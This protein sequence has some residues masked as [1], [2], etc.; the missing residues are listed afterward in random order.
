MHC[1]FCGK[2]LAE[3][4]VLSELTGEIPVYLLDDMLSELDRRH[5][6]YILSEIK[7]RQVII[8][9]CEQIIPTEGFKDLKMI[10]ADGGKFS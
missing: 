5:R 9:S 3:G 7:D 2:E 4:E 10:H 8:T 1:P 6:E